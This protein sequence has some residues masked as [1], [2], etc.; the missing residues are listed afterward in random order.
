MGSRHNCISRTAM[1]V[2]G[3][4][5]ACLALSLIAKFIVVA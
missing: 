1:I 5:L 4:G 2:V 3:T